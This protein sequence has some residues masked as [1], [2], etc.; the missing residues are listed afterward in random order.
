MIADLLI[1]RPEL[2]RSILACYKLVAETLEAMAVDS[3]GM[4]GG[5]HA[6]ASELLAEL[7]GATIESILAG[8]LHEF[9][10]HVIDRGIEL[11]IA[12]DRFYMHG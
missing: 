5:C 9:L 7:Q 6:I 4:R 1:L 8:G 3:G 11:G 10:T 12:I 2:P